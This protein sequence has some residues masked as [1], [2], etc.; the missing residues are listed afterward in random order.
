MLFFFSCCTVSNIPTSYRNNSNI[1]LQ[2]FSFNT[3]PFLFRSF[4]GSLI[5]LETCYLLAAAVTK[6][7]TVKSTNVFR[8]SAI[9]A[10]I[11]KFQSNPRDDFKIAK[12]GTSVVEGGK[13]IFANENRRKDSFSSGS[14]CTFSKRRL[15][16]RASC[17]DLSVSVGVLILGHYNFPRALDGVQS[18]LIMEIK[19]NA[20][21][22]GVLFAI[23]VFD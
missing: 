8:A 18:A 15:F 12:K 21:T 3:V 19:Q 1:R 20:I 6:H 9:N 7:V 14:P 11:K 5:R 4:T 10:Y 23:M 13:L 22:G 16:V 17:P 2:E